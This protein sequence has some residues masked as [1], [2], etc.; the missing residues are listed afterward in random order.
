MGGVAEQDGPARVVGGEGPGEVV[1]VV[2]EHVL[3]P[4]GGEDGGDRVVP[5]A[6]AAQEFGLLVVGG[7]LPRRERGG[8]VGVDP[9][10]LEGLGAPD[11]AAAPGLVRGE[12]GAGHGDQ[13]APGGEP[14]VHRSGMGGEQGGADSGVDAVRADDQ[15]GFQLLL[16][17]GHAGGAVPVAGVGEARGRPGA[18]GAGREQGGEPVDEGGPGQQDQGVAEAGGRGP[19]VRAGQP[20]PARGAQ[21]PVALPGR[22]VAD[23][24]TDA[25]GVE[26]AQAVRG[27]GDGRADGV[28]GGG[29]L[30]HGH[31]PALAV[32][33][34][35]RGQPSDPAADDDHPGRLCH[36]PSFALHL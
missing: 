13:Q 31:R 4:G 29:A 26:S 17:G 5:V 34:G 22:Q 20:A 24:V 15:V 1:D 7:A 12:P 33:G 8:R 16:A 11:A 14:G 9:A 21:S 35:C 36:D 2:P 32:Q 10:V 28:Q 23:L 3:G 19:G 18:D 6:V 27:E 30:Q 25:E